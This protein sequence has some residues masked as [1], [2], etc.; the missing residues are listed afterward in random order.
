MGDLGKRP[1]Q[2]AGDAVRSD[3]ETSDEEYTV[4]S[5]L[6]LLERT[7]ADAAALPSWRRDLNDAAFDIFHE[8]I[9]G[10]AV[11]SMTFKDRKKVT[12]LWT[13]VAPPGQAQ[14][15]VSSY[16]MSTL[17]EYSKSESAFLPGALSSED[18]ED[19][20]LHKLSITYEGQPCDACVCTLCCDP[21]AV[22]SLLDVHEKVI[23]HIDRVFSDAGRDTD[24][25]RALS[26]VS[27]IQRYVNAIAMTNAF[28]VA[29]HKLSPMHALKIKEAAAAAA[30]VPI[31]TNQSHA[32]PASGD[33]TALIDAF[34]RNS[35]VSAKLI[36]QL[37]ALASAKHQRQP[38]LT[39]F[40]KNMQTQM[41]AVSSALRV[42]GERLEKLE[43]SVSGRK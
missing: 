34:N 17:R 35:D 27:I 20:T 5:L 21:S 18:A 43:R 12:D 36:T 29:L 23:S 7:R 28:D 24:M 30:A 11:K 9:T 33:S 37:E 22:G 41:T 2:G 38:D 13:R 40:V 4:D 32:V 8:T 25:E 1:R 15:E 16:A 31:A 3:T 26:L 10:P 42:F 19:Q 6:E 39:E 14:S